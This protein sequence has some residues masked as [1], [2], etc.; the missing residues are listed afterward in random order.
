VRKICFE[1]LGLTVDSLVPQLGEPLGEA[2]LRPTRIYSELIQGL[3]KDLPIHGLAHI[4]GGG[5]SENILRI[6]PGACSVVIDT[7]AWDVPPIFRFLQEAGNVADS[8]MRRTFNMGIGLVTAFSPDDADTVLQGMKDEKPV[9][10][11]VVVA[12]EGGV[13]LCRR[14]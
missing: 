2:L 12:G 4:T 5:I 8:E 7:A 1:R 13:T 6:I 10:I 11:G 9:E 3:L 14:G